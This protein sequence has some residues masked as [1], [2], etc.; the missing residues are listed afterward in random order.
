MLL[1]GVA[2]TSAVAKKEEARE[3]RRGMGARAASKVEGRRPTT[4]D[5]RRIDRQT[6]EG[7]GGDQ[8]RGQTGHH[9]G[10]DDTRTH[11]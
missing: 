3:G 9:E 7:G 8:E 2:L 4:D 10:E 11:M 1:L 6:D 5:R